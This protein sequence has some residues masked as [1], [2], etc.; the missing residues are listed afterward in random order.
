VRPGA[1]SASARRAIVGRR[2]IGYLEPWFW[3]HAIA[4]RD[5]DSHGD[6]PRERS[7]DLATSAAFAPLDPNAIVAPAGSALSHAWHCASAVA[8]ASEGR[9]A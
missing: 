6:D 3:A 4:K 2:G 1:G 7:V 5:A 9:L 8:G